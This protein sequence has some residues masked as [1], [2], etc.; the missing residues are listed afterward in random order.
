MGRRLAVTG[1][2]G[3]VGRHLVKRARERGL[4]AV[5]LVRSPAGARVVEKAGGRAVVGGDLRQAFEGC[6][7][8]VHLAQIGA[9]RGRET[10]ESVNVQGT[11]RV[12]A[13]AREA[14]VPKVVLFS[15]LG[16]AHYGLVP[17]C[18]NRYFLSKL[19]AEIALFRSARSPVV[20][21][22]SYVIGPGNA[23]LAHLLAEMVA[24]QV[25]QVG[26]GSYRLQPIAV[27]D[28]VDG[29]LAAVLGSLP[30]RSL[31]FDLVG[32]EPLALAAFR[33]RLAA[34]A[35]S[36]GRPVRFEVRSVAVE[37]ADAR[38][39]AGGYRGL[40]PDELDCLLCDEVSDPDPLSRLLARPLTPL[41][42]ALRAAVRD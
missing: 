37:E 36:T 16:V 9:E 35:R 38:A 25:E 3:F 33:D 13:A 7:A 27:D 34:V 12:V 17:R 11:E 15:G 2:N 24:G 4:E 6:A 42:D 19:A 29:V 40:G 8:V 5:G 18:T 23:F 31:V 21:R 28:A 32:P 22:P 26:D 14:E 39:R 10:Y 41:D 30:P 1:A 20:F